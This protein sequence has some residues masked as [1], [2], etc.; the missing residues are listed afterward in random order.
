[1]S[2]NEMKGSNELENPDAWST[3]SNEDSDSSNDSFT[4]IDDDPHLE[5]KKNF[6]ECMTSN[7]SI[8]MSDDYRPEM[9][10][11]SPHK[12]NSNSSMTKD[13]NS[14]MTF[15]ITAD[16]ALQVAVHKVNQKKQTVMKGITLDYKQMKN[17]PIFAERKEGLSRRVSICEQGLYERDILKQ[18]LK[19]KLRGDTLEQTLH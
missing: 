12:S 5:V 11:D 13:Y 18:A 19:V 10:K 2:Y 14:L 1:M 9:N 7:T 17:S 15:S 8:N 16:T 6:T 3:T 4:S